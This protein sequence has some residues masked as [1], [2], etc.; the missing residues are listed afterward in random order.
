MAN[1]DEREFRLRP[2]K[3]ARPPR[4]NEATTWAMAFK[5]VM[6]Y[7]RASRR[8]ARPKGLARAGRMSA[9]PRNQRCAVRVT[10]AQN[11]VRGQ[12]RAHGRYIERESAVGDA[13]SGFDR[14]DDGINIAARLE[15]WQAARDQ[16][17]WK[18][19]ISPEFGDRVDFTR[20]TR[21]LMNRIERELGIS[22]EWVAVPH[23]NTEHPHAHIAWRGVG[24][25][26]EP[27]H[28]NRDFVRHGIRSIAEDLCTRQLG[29]RTEF[30]AAEAEHREVSQQRFT[31]LD[32]IISR[33]AQPV[34][35]VSF[36]KLRVTAASPHGRE[37]ETAR[38]RRQHVT[39]RLAVLEHM[40]LAQQM[41]PSTWNLRADFE[42]VLRAMQRA[43]DRQRVLAA[44]GVVVSDERLP[45]EVLDLGTMT[46]VE[47]RVLV[48]GE[49]E[50]S[51]RNYLMLEGTD[52]R[53]YFIHY[54]REMEEAR[55]RGEL[56]PNSYARFRRVFDDGEPKLEV[57]DL[58]DCE[59]IINNHGRLAAAAQALIKRGILP[60]ED[61]WGGWLGRYQRALRQAAEELEYSRSAPVRDKARD[62][63]RDR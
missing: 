13:A 26:R 53:I 40:G 16:R 11:T 21:D 41:G 49:D 9:A 46:S 15:S 37:S 4:R 28:L 61:G 56:R 51:G 31:S 29:H 62:R 27:V 39:A 60:S 63:S 23:V 38:R 1:D 43:A 35:N 59:A 30:D 44:Y 20:L 36:S 19:I 32:R 42:G 5:T 6:H 47:G 3:P 8:S 24:P 25:R 55:A 34:T 18:I 48:H 10:Y 50:Q 33:N 2:R 12:W 57:E 58:G 7:A 22:L 45:S 52:A 14:S 54:T 17:L